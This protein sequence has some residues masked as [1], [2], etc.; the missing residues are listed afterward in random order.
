MS[1]TVNEQAITQWLKCLMGVILVGECL[2]VLYHVN[3]SGV[4]GVVAQIFIMGFY[5]L[6]NV[7]LAS[8]WLRES[9]SPKQAPDARGQQIWVG[10]FTIAMICAGIQV[11]L[12]VDEAVVAKDVLSREKLIQACV[13]RVQPLMAGE[14][15][16]RAWCETHQEGLSE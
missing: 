12:A 13:F 1:R 6:V 7:L 14:T 5:L 11:K 9:F 3:R 15:Q 2:F 10:L 8:Y 16:A 4:V